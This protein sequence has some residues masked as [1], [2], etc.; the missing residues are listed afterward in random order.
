MTLQNVRALLWRGEDLGY[1]GGNT[2]EL[3]TST[4]VVASARP[5]LVTQSFTLIQDITPYLGTSVVSGV[6]GQQRVIMNRSPRYFIT[7]NAVVNGLA[8]QIPIA[9]LQN[10]YLPQ[11]VIGPA[12]LTANSTW[13]IPLPMT[14]ASGVTMQ[15]ANGMT[16][17]T[18]DLM[19][20]Q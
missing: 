14:G 6:R 18:F 9:P 16:A 4:Q 19:V 17:I 11:N 13:P 7:L 20:E 3:T 12:T 5:L 2:R 8:V 1:G 15:L 10:F